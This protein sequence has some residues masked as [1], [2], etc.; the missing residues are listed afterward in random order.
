MSGRP[1]LMSDFRLSVTYTCVVNYL[2]VNLRNGLE[3]MCS[4]LSLSEWECVCPI[5]LRLVSFL[6]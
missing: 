1:R 2:V 5:E 6:K 3:C 4:S